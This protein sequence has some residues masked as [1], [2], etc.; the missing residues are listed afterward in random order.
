MSRHDAT[1]KSDRKFFERRPC[2]KLRL[3]YARSEEIELIPEPLG[4]GFRWFAIVCNVA[5]GL[6]V[7]K[8]M[9]LPEFADPD[10]DSDSDIEFLV[11]TGIYVIPSHHTPL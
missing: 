4:D 7:K 6:R 10:T 2:R 8:F 3:R 1:S 9:G 5:P 11:K